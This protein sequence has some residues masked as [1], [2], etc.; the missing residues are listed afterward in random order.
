MRDLQSRHLAHLFRRHPGLL[1]VTPTVPEAG[2]AR[3]PGDEAY[4]FSD[5]DATIRA[6][7]YIWLANSTG[8]P[9]ASAPVGFADPAHGEGG[10]LPVGL[11]AMA[12]WGDEERL[13]QWATHV[14]GYLNEGLPGGRCRPAEWADVV[15]L[16]KEAGHAG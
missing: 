6:M 1:L 13:L 9:A 15:Q 3:A 11:M 7:M 16:A 4:G 8:C 12:E 5:G 14:E 2:W 10:R